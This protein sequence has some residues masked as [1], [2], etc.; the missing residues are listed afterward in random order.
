MERDFITHLTNC[1]CLPHRLICLSRNDQ[2]GTV[3]SDLPEQ[4]S[5]GWEG[6]LICLSTIDD[7]VQAYQANQAIR[8]TTK[9]CEISRLG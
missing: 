5:S 3:L 9:N 8:Q 2:A 4:D 6:C 1:L 7:P